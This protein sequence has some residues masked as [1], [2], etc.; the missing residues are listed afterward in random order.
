MCERARERVVENV[1]GTAFE[2]GHLR[3]Q[4]RQPAHIAGDKNHE[5]KVLQKVIECESEWIGLSLE[6]AHA[7]QALRWGEELNDG[8]CMKVQANYE[9]RAGGDGNY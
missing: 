9:V 6:L 2:V 5:G 4:V 3:R 7:V 1:P 8:L